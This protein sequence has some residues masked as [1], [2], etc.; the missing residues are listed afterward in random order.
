MIDATLVHAEVLRAGIEPGPEAVEAELARLLDNRAS[1]ADEAAR[2]AVLAKLERAA[3]V[4]ARTPTPPSASEVAAAYSANPG[5]WAQPALAVVE[6]YLARVAVGADTSADDASKAALSGVVK[7][8]AGGGKARPTQG[9][10]WLQRFEVEQNG[11]EP[12]LER[13]VFASQTASQT[14]TSWSAPVRTKVGW[15][16][17]RVLEREPAVVRPLV[18]VEPQVRSAVTLRRDRATEDMLIAWLRSAATITIYV[19]W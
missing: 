16:V 15:A 19:R 3:L 18:E 13:V 7:A 5:L 11:L 14:S 2:G 12:E 10:E 8:L 9:V 4:L 6:G 1:A 17:V